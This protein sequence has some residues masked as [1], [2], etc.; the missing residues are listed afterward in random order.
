MKSE[1]VRVFQPMNFEEVDRHL[2]IMGDLKADCAACRELG[3]DVYTAKTC[4][5]CGTPF[6]YLTS[7]RIESHPGERFHE[8]RRLSEKRPDLIFIDY[9][10]YSKLLGKKKA[11]DF[12]G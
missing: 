5:G 10:D 8:V 12:F 4:P 2:L 7:R 3:I 6:K 1:Y 9:S 11:R